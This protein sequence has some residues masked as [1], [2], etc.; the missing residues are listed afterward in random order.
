M[1]EAPSLFSGIASP[2]DNKVAMKEAGYLCCF[3]TGI[4]ADFRILGGVTEAIVKKALLA[5]TVVVLV[6]GTVV[7]ANKIIG[8]GSPQVASKIIGNG[9]TASGPVGGEPMATAAA[10]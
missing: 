1:P 9:S 10:K 4:T 8:N 3:A 6:G 5:L 7:I 2:A